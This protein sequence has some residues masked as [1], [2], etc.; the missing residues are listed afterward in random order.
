ML[1][2]LIET[3][4]QLQEFK[5]KGYKEVFL[6]P[7]LFN[8]NIHPQLNNLSALYIKPFNNDKGYL[9]CISHDE[10]FSLDITA[11]EIILQDFD[12]IYV[13]DLKQISYWFLNKNLQQILFHSLPEIE[14]TTN[15][16][17][18][19]YQ[20]YPNKQDLN[21]IVPIVKHYEKCELIWE[22][23]K[24]KLDK[25][26]NPYYNEL[27]KLFYLIEKNGIKIDDKLFAEYY[28]NYNKSFNIQYDTIYSSYNLH[29]TTGRPANSFNG[30][31]FAALK[32]NNGERQCFIPKNDYLI[33]YDINAYHPNLAAGLIG[34][35]F[36]GENPYEYF[37]REALV[38]LEEAKKLMFRQIYGGVYKEY[39]NIEFF[40]K[41][42]NYTYKIW[43]EFQDSG[44]FICP[45]SNHIFYKDKLE[46][47]NPSKLFNYLLQNQET[48][49]N[50]LLLKQILKEL[51]N[52][53]TQLVLY[54][55]DAFLFD[56]AE[57]EQELMNSI[58]IIF[59]N[60]FN[61]KKQTGINYDF[62]TN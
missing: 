24:N 45:G 47:M 60:K 28:E 4:E 13:R 9:L 20:K 29:T 50:T 39:K 31:N 23:I 34:F 25:S 8:D 38:E 52:K 16:H 14:V 12:T 59:K 19:F 22:H 5:N 36:K 61:I 49:N 2:W 44:K 48:Y 7:I 27:S 56:V 40:A 37:S 41:I 10:T 3:E 6:E 15:A 11:I 57:D 58:E 18:Y 21:K 46:D 33:E 32:K 54:T 51:Y 43:K 30:I 42:E 53:K 55:Y 26:K 17:N 62:R 1:Y 35:D